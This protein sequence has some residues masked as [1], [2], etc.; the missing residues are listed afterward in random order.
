[1]RQQLKATVAD[2]GASLSFMPFFIKAASMALAQYPMLNAHV[3]EDCTEIIY[4]GS[5]NI[6]LAMN[7]PSGL[8]VPNVKVAFDRVKLPNRREPIMPH[9]IVKTNLFMKSLAS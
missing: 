4:R 6:G 2:R 7:T 8:I 1:M 5:H 3:N 9:R